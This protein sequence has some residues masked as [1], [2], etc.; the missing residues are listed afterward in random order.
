M[1]ITVSEQEGKIAYLLLKS[2]LRDKEG[3]ANHKPNDIKREVVKK[4]QELG[5]TADELYAL[6]RRIHNELIDAAR[7]PEKMDFKQG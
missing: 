2:V 6:Y 5:V 7:L 4:A 3:V 1:N